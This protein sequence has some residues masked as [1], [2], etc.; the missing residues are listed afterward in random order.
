MN[1]LFDIYLF[2]M[3]YAVSRMV[4]ILWENGKVYDVDI[5]AVIIWGFTPGINT[6]YVILSIWEWSVIQYSVY[7]RRKKL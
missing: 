2:S 5:F 3:S 1:I 4:W 7:K 6:L